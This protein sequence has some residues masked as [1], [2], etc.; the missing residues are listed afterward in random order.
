MSYEAIPGTY[1]QRLT[2]DA[3]RAAGAPPDAV[4]AASAA[5]PQP[6]GK[7][8]ADIQAY[9]RYWAGLDAVWR[10]L[11]TQ[12][13]TRAHALTLREL[14]YDSRTRFWDLHAEAV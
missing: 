11:H 1:Q 3:L 6:S 13:A 9:S 2:L 4:A 5:L 7:L 12:A 10:K 14:A 8:D